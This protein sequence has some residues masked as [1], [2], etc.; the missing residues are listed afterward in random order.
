M[1]SMKR[2]ARKSRRG[3]S[4]L[5]LARWGGT[6]A[7]LAGVSYGAW[8]YLDNPDAGGVVIGV[9]LPVLALTTPALFLGGLAGLYARLQGQGS[10]SGTIGL[11]MGLLGTGLGIFNGV[12]DLGVEWMPILFAGLTVVGVATIVRD[13]PRRSLGALVLASGTIG[14]AS[15]LT[16]PAF[17]G[18]LVSARPVHVAFAALFCMSAIAWGWVL[19]RGVS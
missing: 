5:T 12:G 7:C 2:S 14:W 18:V 13:A 19:F 17:S 16:D 6:S 1:S 11:L 8:G 4:P 15:A 3:G 9:V 10:R